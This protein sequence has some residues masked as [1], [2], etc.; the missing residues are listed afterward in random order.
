MLLQYF[1]SYC[2]SFSIQLRHVRY[3]KQ[4]QMWLKM[5]IICF[6]RYCQLGVFD[7]FTSSAWALN[8]VRDVR[9]L[10]QN[11]AFQELLAGDDEQIT[12]TGQVSSSVHRRIV[13]SCIIS[14][15]ILYH[16]GLTFVPDRA[17]WRRPLPDLRYTDP[18]V[19]VWCSR[20]FMEAGDQFLPGNSV[21]ILLAPYPI[22][23]L[24]NF[25]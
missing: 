1:Y 10:S 4:K 2:N 6:K 7:A 11:I 17:V 12:V 19:S 16:S 14:Y 23:T 21:I 3:K 24:K 18:V 15:C 9:Y 22:S 20:H 13:S 8:D 25:N 5:L